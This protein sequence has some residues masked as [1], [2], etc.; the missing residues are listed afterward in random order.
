MKLILYFYRVQL[1]SC[2]QIGLVRG[3]SNKPFYL[4]PERVHVQ[5]HWALRP[6]E[7]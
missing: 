5:P 4:H 1:N 2:I 6:L 3:V 7:N